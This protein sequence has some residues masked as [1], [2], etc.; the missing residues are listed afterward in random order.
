MN[1]LISEVMTPLPHSVASS[2]PVSVAKEMLKRYNIRH[3]P[4]RKD[5]SL[6]GIVTDR[7]I[8]FALAWERALPADLSVEDIFIPDPYCVTPATPLREVA[9]KMASDRIGSAL[10]IEGD[11]LVGIFTAVDACRVLSVLLREQELN[12]KLEVNA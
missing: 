5:G 9:Q 8:H 1:M 12:Q 11:E 3:L 10:V 4:V 6:I 7:D 2:Q